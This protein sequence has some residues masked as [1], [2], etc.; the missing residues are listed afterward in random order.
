M[1]DKKRPGGLTA[2]AVIN[3]I[4]AGL[5]ILGL[6][7]MA[8]INMINRT[9]MAGM[10]EAQKAQLAAEVAA[11]QNMG[12]SMF[13]LIIIINIIAFTLLFFSG[14]GYLKLK[15][16]LGRIVGNL[17][18]IIGIIVVIATAIILP[19]EIGGGFS[20][21][22]IIGIIYPVLTLI[23]INTTFKDDLVN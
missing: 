21:L 8:T 5:N 1:E 12:Q 9:P 17:Y 15:K 4:F 13:L 22:R 20:I 10:T 19:K 18:G 7:G 11:F 23:L 3:F 2:L 6:L 14:I 16:V